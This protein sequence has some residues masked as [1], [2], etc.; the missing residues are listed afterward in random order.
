MPM[1]GIQIT[2]T[3]SH[4]MMSMPYYLALNWGFAFAG[5]Q[6]LM[7]MATAAVVGTAAGMAG[8]YKYINYQGR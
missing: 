3:I 1:Q 2:W 7:H 8:Y 5:K 6:I 4:F